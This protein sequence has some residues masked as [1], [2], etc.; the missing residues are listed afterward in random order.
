MEANT[1]RETES[2]IFIPAQ[3]AVCWMGLLAEPQK[4]WKKGYS[5]M[6]LAECW[7]EANDFPKS[8]RSVFRKSGINIFE[9]IKFLL[10]FP[11]YKVSLRGG[12]R[13]SQNDIFVLAKGDGQLVSIMVEGK[14]KEK[15][16][17]TISEWEVD[18]NKETGKEKRLDFLCDILQLD[19]NKIGHI[20]YQLLHRTASA[21]IE[22]IKFNAQNAL[23][24]VHSFDQ[25]YLWF[26]DYSNF[27]ALFGLD[28]KR[29]SL[30]GP[31]NIRGIN[32]YFCWVKG[33]ERFIK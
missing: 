14:V 16:D 22:A 21:L 18:K 25:E 6:A 20:R 27:L 19:K 10:A 1:A 33:E 30:V 4:Q 29:D 28:A 24:L 15:F 17:K 7:Q 32:L 8:V 2:K 11:E 26:N 9:K 3:K 23:M 12:K 13:P 31:I 5:A